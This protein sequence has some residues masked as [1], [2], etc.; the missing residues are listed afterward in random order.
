MTT[1]VRLYS[2]ECG[3][4]RFSVETLTDAVQDLMVLKAIRALELNIEVWLGIGVNAT[5][6]TVFDT[7]PEAARSLL[8]SPNYSPS[9]A[10]A[11]V[12][13]EYILTERPSA[14]SYA[15]IK[16]HIDR[17][18]TAL[19]PLSPGILIGGA[20]TVANLDGQL[21]DGNMVLANIHAWWSGA[22]GATAA[23]DLRASFKSAVT[24]PLGT[25]SNVTS[26]IGET[27][28]PVSLGAPMVN[29]NGVAADATQLNGA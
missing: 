24:D 19:R 11:I 3:Q 20:D 15:A 13:N 23:D 2:S 14:E 26:F 25:G 22:S 6:A 18:S 21:R 7:D 17:V 28:W 5:N 10:G 4:V 1:R 12:G 16:S 27:G 9:I 8:R 29:G